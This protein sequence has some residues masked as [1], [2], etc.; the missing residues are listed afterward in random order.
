MRTALR[1]RTPAIS[2]RSN[3]KPFQ[4]A[5]GQLQQALALSRET[6]NR[7]GEADALNGLGELTTGQHEQASIQYSAALGLACQIGG[8]YQQAL[9]HRGLTRAHQAVGDSGRAP[10]PL[11]ASPHPLR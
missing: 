9:A 10:P 8:N 1:A 3:R 2:A 11:A 5:T 7:D 4:Q 6:G